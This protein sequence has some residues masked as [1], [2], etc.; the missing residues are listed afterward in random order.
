[1]GVGAALAVA[2]AD[3]AEEADGELVCCVMGVPPV[4]QETTSVAASSTPAPRA[5][6]LGVIGEE[7]C[8]LWH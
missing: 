6:I 8:S 4:E 7:P 3:A 1:L 2:G 5:D